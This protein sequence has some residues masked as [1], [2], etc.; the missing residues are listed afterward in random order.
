MW[1]V[2]GLGNPGRE[3]AAHRHNVGFMVADELARRA[4]VTWQAKFGGEVGTGLLGGSKAILLKPMEY[5]N[6]SGRAVQ[7]TAAFYQV[8]PGSIVVAHDELDLELATLRVKVGGGHAGHNGLRSIVQELGSPDFVRIRCGIGR[9]PGGGGEKVTGHVLG[10]FA[11]GETEVAKILVQ[12]GADAI[13]D[14]IA[15]GVAPA[16]NKWNSR[17]P[18]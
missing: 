7:K 18:S 5:M 8:E 1:L 16:M 13:E 11:K 4:G 14:V 10:G 3:Y 2:V 9:P 17:S 15:K 6:L 12:E